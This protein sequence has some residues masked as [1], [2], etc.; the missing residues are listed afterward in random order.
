M[1]R[2]TLGRT[3]IEVSDYCL[4]T[5]T[6]GNQ[7]PEAEAHSQIDA[8]LDA[9]IDFMDTAEMYP[10][11]PVRKETIGGTE[12]VIGNWLEKTGRRADVVIATKHTGTSEMVRDNRPIGADTVRDTLEGSLRRLKTDYV[13]VYQFH[14]PNRGSFM[15]RQNWVFDPRKQPSAN[16]ILDEFAAIMEVLAELVKEG[17]I[18]AFG[19]SNDS[20]WGTMQWL[21]AAERAGGP[22]VATM[23]NEYSLLC[24]LYDTDM[25]ELAH[26]EDITLLAFSPLAA[27]F[28]TGKYQNGAIP[29]G[30]RM[31]INDTMGG[32][33][34]AR[35][36]EAT[37]A[38]LDIATRHG[39]DPVHLSLAWCVQRP[40]PTIPIFGATTMPQLQRILG[41]LDLTLPEEVLDEVSKAHRAHPMPY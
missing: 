8:A 19:L 29:E 2:T 38:Y 28:L 4:G 7:T 15:F 24:R 33:K 3:G 39:L 40:F 12:E 10:V 18:R 22:R 36:F 17:K 34:S 5:M 41:G 21:A 23:Q 35:V 30:S 26:H 37:Q 6:W 27:G 9:G 14:W 32:R 11:A 25:A 16:E 31:S 13:D 1:N 20:A